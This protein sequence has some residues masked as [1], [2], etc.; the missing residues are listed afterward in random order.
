MSGRRDQYAVYRLRGSPDYLDSLR[1]QPYHAWREQNRKVTS[2]LYRQ[3]CISQLDPPFA[4]T[5]LR[6]RLETKLPAGIAGAPLAVSDVLAVTKGGITAAYYVDPDRLVVLTGFFHVASSSVL[7][8][9]ETTDYQIEGRPGNWLAAEES[10][11]DGRQFFLMQSQE[12]GRNAAYAVLDSEGRQAA[13]DTAVGFSDEVIRQIRE[14]MQRQMVSADK[15]RLSADSRPPLEN[16]QKSYENGEY[17]RSAEMA[18]EQNYSM[19]DGRMN[20]MPPKPIIYKRRTGRKRKNGRLP[21]KGRESVLKRL[22]QYQT[23]LAMQRGQ[24][25]MGHEEPEAVERKK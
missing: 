1:G 8:S 19:I 9:L 22:K 7:I 15:T 4:L 6:R 16:W 21:V 5:E 11:I 13:Q 14:Y 23:E 24:P 25:T 10:W 18:E 20:N 12:F 2:D 3:V 17:L